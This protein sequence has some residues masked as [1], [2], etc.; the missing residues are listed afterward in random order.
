MSF[1]D[2][3][4]PAV[5]REQRFEVPT[6]CLDKAEEEEER[7]DDDYSP[8]TM[9]MG[10]H[11]IA[12]TEPRACHVFLMDARP[13]SQ[14]TLLGRARGRDPV[15][16]PSG[17]FFAIKGWDLD[18]GSCVA[19]MHGL[20]G[21]IL[22]MY[23]LTQPDSGLGLGALLQMPPGSEMYCQVDHLRWQP[24]GRGLCCRF[25]PSLLTNSHEFATLLFQ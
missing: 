16:D 3:S 12:L 15:C 10:R 11:S 22:A 25:L 2:L 14:G 23:Q 5:V 9:A 18:S 19:I 20:S 21:D 6:E 17:S 4:R 7:N 1:V 24:G 8:R 13:G